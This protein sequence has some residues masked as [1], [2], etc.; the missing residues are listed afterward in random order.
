MD[1]NN[2]DGTRI[3][4]RD[5]TALSTVQRNTRNNWLARVNHRELKMVF[6]KFVNWTRCVT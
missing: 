6:T 1:E 4:N 2:S 3:F 5:E